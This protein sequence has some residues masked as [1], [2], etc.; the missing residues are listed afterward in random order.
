MPKTKQISPSKRWIF[1]W[2]NYSA[3]ADIQVLLNCFQQ[4][5]SQWA[6]QQETGANGTP[7]LQGAVIFHSKCRPLSLC[8]PPQIHWEKMKAKDPM[9]AFRYSSKEDTRT[10]SV[11]THGIRLPKKISSISLDQLRPWQIEIY[12]K[13]KEEPD[14]RTIHWYWEPA[15]NVGKTAFTKFLCVN[16]PEEALVVSGKSTDVFYGIVKFREVHGDYPRI[17]VYD[18]PRSVDQQYVCFQALE[19]VKDGIFFSGKYE[20]CMVVMNCPHLVVFSNESPDYAKL[21]QDR[22]NVQLINN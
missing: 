14:S 2:N 6:F 21:S 15:G 3:P 5:G 11:W 18:I 13:I 8:L 22:W 19:K 7:H 1:V 10:G 12:N 17:I 9:E 16:H 20:G 4:K